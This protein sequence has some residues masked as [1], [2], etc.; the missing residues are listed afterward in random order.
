M[1]RRALLY[2]AMTGAVTA[3]LMLSAAAAQADTITNS[4]SLTDGWTYQ[5]QPT[6]NPYNYNQM[7]GAGD[8]TFAQ[9][10]FDTSTWSTGGVMPFGHNV[11]GNFSPSSTATPWAPNTDMLLRKTVSL[12]PGAFNVHI[13]GTIDNDISI[14]L[15]GTYLGSDYEGFCRANTIAMT[16]PGSAVQNGDNLLAVRAHDYGDGTYVNLSLTYSINV[17]TTPP[18]VSVS[19]VADGQNGWNVSSPVT[20]TVSASDSGSGLAGSP[21]CT[22]DGNSTSLTAS[23]SGTWT[24][25]VSSDGSHSV[26]C[27]ASDNSGNTENAV[28]TVNIDATRP[29]ITATS[30]SSGASY[31]LGSG[32]VASYSCSDGGSGLASCSG[33]VASGANFDTSSVGPHTFTVNAADNAG[34]TA[35]TPVQYSV[36]YKFGGLLAPVNSPPTVN[37]GKAGRSYPVK[38]QLQ[39][40]N[41]NYISSLS[42]VKSVTYKAESCSALSSDPTDALETTTTGSTSLRYDSTA[43]QYVYNWATPGIGCYTLFVTLDSGQ[44]YPAYFN[45]S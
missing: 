9:P 41:G 44:T 2:L 23:G 10:S 42:A 25:P 3:G 17:D 45:L 1:L 34:N 36:G 6:A 22:V 5:E 24:F 19:H 43:N 28:D 27:Q 30:P 40:G 14:Y 35:S 37:T 21:S 18:S 8:G 20:E 31:L 4:V 33:P 11:C 39:D 26:A 7:S 29:G 15:N 16:A 13:T 32:Q 12:P 38:F